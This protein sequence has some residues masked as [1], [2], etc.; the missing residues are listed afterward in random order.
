LGNEEGK[1]VI[2]R[3]GSNVVDPHSVNEPP[4]PNETVGFPGGNVQ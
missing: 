4:R 2:R 3:S 1:N